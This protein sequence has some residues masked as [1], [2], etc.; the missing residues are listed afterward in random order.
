MK[1][2][3][4]NRV[5][6]QGLVVRTRN[7]DE[8]QPSTARIGALWAEFGQQIAP[9]LAPGALTYGVY[10]HYESNAD[11]MFDV[12]AGA[13]AQSAP[14]GDAL[15]LTRVDIANGPYLVF[16]THG[17]PPQAVIEAWGQI[18]RYF[19]DP[20][21]VHQRAYTTDFERYQ[22]DGQID[23]YIAVLPS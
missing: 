19:A 16:E 5:T 6:V 23:I 14:F 15:G 4:I 21:C 20:E 7:A 2:V 10:H 22:V 1:M 9:S 17:A 8:A 12:L 18:W 3:E 11:G 13:D